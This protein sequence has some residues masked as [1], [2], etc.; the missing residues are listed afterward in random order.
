MNSISVQSQ[1]KLL[2]LFLFDSSNFTGT[3]SFVFL[4]GFSCDCNGSGCCKFR[5]LPA[6]HWHHAKQ[7][8]MNCIKAYNS[9]VLKNTQVFGSENS[10]LHLDQGMHWAQQHKCVPCFALISQQCFLFA[11]LDHKSGQLHRIIHNSSKNLI[12]E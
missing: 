3:Q 8:L 11:S 10:S 9:P 2:V 12:S 5:T 4:Q 1:V 7:P 6:V